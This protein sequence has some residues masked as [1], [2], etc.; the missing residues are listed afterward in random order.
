MSEERKKPI[1]PWIVTLLIGLPVLYVLSLP[2]VELLA[3]KV[4]A[5]EWLIA[6]LQ[7]FYTPFAWMLARSPAPVQGWYLAYGQGCTK[8]LG[9]GSNTPVIRSSRRP[10]H[11]TNSHLRPHLRRA[12][13]FLRS[14][15]RQFSVSVPCKLIPSSRTTQSESRRK[16]TGPFRVWLDNKKGAGLFALSVGFTMT[17]NRCRLWNSII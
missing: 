7:V 11:L 4:G 16:A 15:P 17:A 13:S 9:N 6:P 14:P 3:M 8:I 10:G 2:P 1:C 5:P 12:S